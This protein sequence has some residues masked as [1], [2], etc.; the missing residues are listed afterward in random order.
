[1]HLLSIFWSLLC[2]W[3]WEQGA[4]FLLD[5]HPKQQKLVRAENRKQKIQTSTNPG[6][7]VRNEL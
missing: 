5:L 1:M 4:G 7:N 2:L 3:D 6:D